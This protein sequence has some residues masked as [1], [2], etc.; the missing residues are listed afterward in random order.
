MA[1]VAVGAGIAVVD[2][3][4]LGVADDP[5]ID[6]VRTAFG[7]VP[8]V[9]AI[10]EEGVVLGI[11]EDE[12]KD[13][14]AALVEVLSFGIFTFASGRAVLVGDGL[15]LVVEGLWFVLVELGLE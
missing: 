15:D 9:E 12:D 13:G 6:L 3:D 1:V 14:R 4:S 10:G 8:K 11:D 2:G 5:D 7:M